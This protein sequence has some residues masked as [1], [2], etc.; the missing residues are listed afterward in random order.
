MNIGRIF[1]IKSLGKIGETAHV[2]HSA[3]DAIKVK[4]RRH[5]GV[6]IDPVLA[7]LSQFKAQNCPLL[8]GD[9]IPNNGSSSDNLNAPQTLRVDYFE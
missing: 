1:E 7:I 6:F 3:N 8:G 5:D 2:V 4:S 9:R